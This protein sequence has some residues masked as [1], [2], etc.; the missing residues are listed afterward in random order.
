MHRARSGR[1]RRIRAVLSTLTFAVIVAAYLT[2]PGMWQWARAAS[3]AAKQTPANVVEQVEIAADPV[4]PALVEM[5]RNASTSLQAPPLILTYHDV[6]YHDDRYT[7][8]PEAFATQMQVIKDAGWTTT[9]AAQ[10]EAWLRGEP[11]PPHSVMITFD[12]GA[13][14][15]WKYADP[16]LARNGQHALAYVVT[17]FVGTRVPYY[18]TWPELTTM[19]QSGRWDLEAHSHLGHV[20]IP[21]DPKGSE[22]PFLTNRQWLTEPRRYETATEYHAR[23]FTDLAECKRQFVEHGLPEPDFFAYPFSAH[24]DDPAATDALRSAIGSLYEA[25]MLDQADSVTTTTAANISHGNI[26]RMDITSDVTIDQWV[27]RLA[28][29]SPL[30]PLLSDPVVDVEGWT[31]SSQVPAP[32]T[33]DETGAILLDPGPGGEVSRQYARY[34]TSMWS[35]YT[36]SA[37]IGDFDG[38]SDGTS[39]GISVLAGDSRHQVHLNIG[40]GSYSVS[41]GFGEDRPAFASGPL[42]WSEA[43]RHHVVMQVTPQAV[44]ITIDDDTQVVVPFDPGE[45][46]A[47]A[48]GIGING[49]RQYDTSPIPRISGLTVH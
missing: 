31:D 15:I 44:T 22:G 3:F 47:V 9:T 42:S 16:I 13:R 49:H 20:K 41:V 24:D 33:V 4:D 14:G 21:T 25:A 8:T 46:R 5:L 17:G 23:I 27:Q 32:V 7:I 39:T 37:D 34:R 36:V 43:Q 10:L 18:V 38:S 45:P 1:V 35:N 2:V 29:A 30:E 26:A 11:L 48:G 28:M 19:H 40:G 12:D 6:G